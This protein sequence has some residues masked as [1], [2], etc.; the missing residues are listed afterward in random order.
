MASLFQSKVFLDGIYQWA[1]DFLRSVERKDRAIAVK[2]DMQMT[3]LAG[4][5][6]R[7]LFFQPSFELAVLQSA[8]SV[9]LTGQII[10]T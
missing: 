7:P 6:F 2:L 8:D 10:N 3:T 4:R 1:G 9:P 5:E